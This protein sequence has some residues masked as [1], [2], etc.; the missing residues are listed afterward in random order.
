MSNE[1]FDAL[2]VSQKIEISGYIYE[3]IVKPNLDTLHERMN[4]MEKFNDSIN[5]DYVGFKLAYHEHVKIMVEENITNIHN[6]IDELEKHV[7]DMTEHYM[8]KVINNAVPHKC[9]VCEGNGKIYMNNVVSMELI[10]QGWLIDSL[11]YG[12]KECQACLGKAILWG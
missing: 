11:G 6:R 2:S 5:Q 3:V 8:R 12:Y 4:V 10:A 7:K 9:P 1:A